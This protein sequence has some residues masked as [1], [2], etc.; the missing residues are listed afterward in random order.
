MLP[1]EDKIQDCTDEWL[2]HV[3]KVEERKVSEK[4]GPVYIQREKEYIKA[5]G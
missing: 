2:Q 5:Q 3:Q 1:V 4:E